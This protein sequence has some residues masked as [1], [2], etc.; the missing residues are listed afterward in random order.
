MNAIIKRFL[1]W[2]G[3]KEKL[4]EQ[5]HRP[6]LFKEGEIW[7]CYMGEKDQIVVLVQGRVFDYRRLKEKIAELEESESRKIRDG[8]ATLHLSYKNRPSAVSGEGRG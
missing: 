3:L 6:P 5:K 8:Y 2:V 7:W 4:H 1:E